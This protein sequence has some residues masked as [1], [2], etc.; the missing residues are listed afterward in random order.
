VAPRQKRYRQP[1]AA[2]A[3]SYPARR[4][5]RTPDGRQ[6]AEAAEPPLE[7]KRRRGGSRP[8]SRTI[9]VRGVAPSWRRGPLGGHLMQR[10]A[11]GGA[12]RHPGRRRQPRTPRCAAGLYADRRRW[13]GPEPSPWALAES[14]PDN[15]QGTRSLRAPVAERGFRVLAALGDLPRGNH[16]GSA[17][18]VAAAPQGLSPW[19]TAARFARPAAWPGCK[20]RRAVGRLRAVDYGDNRGPLFIMVEDGLPAPQEISSPRGLSGGCCCDATPQ[21][22]K[23]SR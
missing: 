13:A 18:A 3:S 4:R 7:N 16:S 15:P 6:A 8:L 1:A 22:R 14:A 21:A 19:S 10:A 9:R 2:P 17:R 23:L 12:G 11:P 20:R 5:S